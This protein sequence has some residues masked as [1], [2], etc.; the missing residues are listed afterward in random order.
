MKL[1]VYQ[2]DDPRPLG[3]AWRNAPNW[4]DDDRLI[5]VHAPTRGKAQYLIAGEIGVAFLES[6]VH[7]MPAMDDL[8][9]TGWNLLVT[10]CCE[11]CE[12]DGCYR[13]IY[14]EDG[15]GID[16]PW[17]YDDDGNGVAAVQGSHGTAYCSAVC[18]ASDRKSSQ[19][20][21]HA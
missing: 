16:G 3:K 4:L 7:R 12:C 19:E 9:V 14:P 13:E 10:G 21:D 6:P 1:T 18:L 2:R 15:N 17:S 20:A 5:V 11:W 8:P